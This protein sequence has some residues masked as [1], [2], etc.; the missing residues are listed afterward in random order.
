MTTPTID[1]FFVTVPSNDPTNI[2]G[3]NAN[4]TVQMPAEITL[5]GTWKVS[6]LQVDFQP[7][8]IFT[9]YYAYCG[10]C[11]PSCVGS[12]LVSLLGTLPGSPI[13]TPTLYRQP[14]PQQWSVVAPT[15]FTSIQISILDGLG[16]LPVFASPTI[17]TLLFMRVK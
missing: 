3:S 13:I 1:T 9:P 15:G 5:N 7:A 11:Q 16:N 12:F 8:A 10:I 17:V 6:M 4:F 14:D 2:S